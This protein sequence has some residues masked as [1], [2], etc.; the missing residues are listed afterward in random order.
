MNYCLKVNLI[1]DPC[2]PSVTDICLC[3]MVRGSATHHA[4]L[5]WRPPLDRTSHLTPEHVHRQWRLGGWREEHGSALLSMFWPLIETRNC[6]MCCPCYWSYFQCRPFYI[7][8]AFKSHWGRLCGVVDTCTVFPTV[9]HFC[10]WLWNAESHY[11]FCWL[12]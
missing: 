7:G 3:Q 11:T 4:S 1:A 5:H 10:C 6:G 2:C 9:G 8:V 12:L